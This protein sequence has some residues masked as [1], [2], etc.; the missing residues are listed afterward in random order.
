[1]DELQIR[2][3]GPLTGT[4]C[5]G[6]EWLD[7]CG[8]AGDSDYACRSR[9]QTLR[10][11]GPGVLH[12]RDPATARYLASV[13]GP[14]FNTITAAPVVLPVL[15]EYLPQLRTR[16]ALAGSLDESIYAIRGDVAIGRR[17][18]VLRADD[19][20]GIV[21][22]SAAQKLV[23]MLFCKDEVLERLWEESA[24][25]LTG[26]A[27]AGYDLV[28]APSYST[29]TPRPRTEHLYN[30]KRSLIIYR[31]LQRLGVRAVPRV[32]WVTRHDVRR[33]AA[34]LAANPWVE[35]VAV[36]TSTYRSEQDWRRLLNGLE[37]LERLSLG[38]LR[39]LIN[40]PT[41]SAR[42]ADVFGI[43]ASERVCWTSATLAPPPG[44]DGQLT[45]SPSRVGAEGFA[46]RCS[47]RRAAIAEGRRIA[48][49]RAVE[50]QPEETDTERTG[51]PQAPESRREPRAGRRL[52]L[53]R[54]G[55]LAV[56][57]NET[58]PSRATT[59]SATRA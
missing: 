2:L 20:R 14:E 15:P 18:E 8:A 9:A 31:A 35:L 6:C 11:S 30:L 49:E 17:A 46:L 22:L 28:V 44:P 7:V 51:I 52:G 58:V 39:Y 32:A 29:W 19:L 55:S 54:G 5:G 47:A 40:G 24:V 37:L 16:S 23:L 3:F 10:E 50:R 59:L 21:G 43:L 25:L 33:F 26:I 1:V 45:L 38:R 56:T 53:G 48:R 34:W 57:A 12:A 41:I 13:G 36:D 42:H 27:E 4:L